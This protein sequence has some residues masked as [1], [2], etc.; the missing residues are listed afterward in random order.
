M[1]EVVPPL[2]AALP[3]LDSAWTYRS[4]RYPTQVNATPRAFIEVVISPASP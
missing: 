3:A 1:T 2:A 4:F